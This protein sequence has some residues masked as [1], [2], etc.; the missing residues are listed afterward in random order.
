MLLLLQLVI[1]LWVE[2]NGSVY[3]LMLS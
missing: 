2:D 3:H 1:Y